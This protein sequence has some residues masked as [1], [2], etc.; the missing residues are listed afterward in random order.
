MGVPVRQRV[1]GI[2]GAGRI[3]SAI[4]RTMK[5][6]FDNAILYYGR[7]RK[8]E[9]ENSL[10]AQRRDLEEL[11]AETDFIFVAVPLSPETRYLIDERQLDHVKRGAVLV[12]IARA[13]II[14]DGALTQ[15]L[16]DGHIFGA[17]LDVYES[18]VLQC[19][20]PNLVL[21]AHMANGEGKAMQ[22]TVELA[23]RNV[24]AVLSDETPISPVTS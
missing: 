21:T 24:V 11:L 20:H 16:K 18:K 4:A 7:T 22:A 23:V 13:G 6:G 19:H 9:L 2:V 8:T 14:D 10:G 3:G 1:T 15:L 5:L 17:G 12:N